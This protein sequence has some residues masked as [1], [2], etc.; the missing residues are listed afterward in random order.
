MTLGERWRAIRKERNLSLRDVEEISLLFAEQED[1][2]DFIIRKSRLWAIEHG[3]KPG[4]V[5][6]L[7]LGKIYGL[8]IEELLCVWSGRDRQK[9]PGAFTPR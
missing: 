2:W 3:S 8:S 6:M 9:Q 5:K 4:P 1:N 7:V